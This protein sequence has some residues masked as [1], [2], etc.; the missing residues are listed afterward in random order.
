MSQPNRS[1][2]P[3]CGTGEATDE[4]AVVEDHQLHGGAHAERDDRQVDAACAHR[5]DG[6]QGAEGHGGD[7]AGEQREP[8]RPAADG[9]QSARRPSA[10]NPARANW[11]SDSWPA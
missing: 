11:P 4:V 9:D 3:T 2:L 8:E 6:E 10:P 1:G 5:R 7:D